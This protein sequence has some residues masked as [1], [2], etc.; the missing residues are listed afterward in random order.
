MGN[1]RL[2]IDLLKT[3]RFSLA[4]EQIK[5]HDD[6]ARMLDATDAKKES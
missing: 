3:R 6:I 4:T 1:W 2:G 5:Q